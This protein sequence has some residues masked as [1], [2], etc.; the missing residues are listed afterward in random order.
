[1]SLVVIATK[2]FYPF[3]DT[4]RYPNS[5]NDPAAQVMDWQAWAELQKEFDAR[6]KRGAR[7]GKGFDIE[8]NEEDVLQMTPIQL[9]DYMDWYSKMW[10]DSNKGT[11]LIPKE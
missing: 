5:L 8:V 3:D 6:G 11:I 2:L 4:K 9:D 1:M 10:I 7:I